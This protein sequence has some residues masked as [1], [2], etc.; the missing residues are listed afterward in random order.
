MQKFCTLLIQGFIK[1]LPKEFS[2]FIHIRARSRRSDATFGVK[3]W[4]P[5]L[6][7][8]SLLRNAYLNAAVITANGQEFFS[9]FQNRFLRSHPVLAVDRKYAKSSAVACHGKFIKSR[10]RTAHFLRNSFHSRWKNTSGFTLAQC[11]VV[12]WYLLGDSDALSML[13]TSRDARARRPGNS[14]ELETKS[15]NVSYVRMLRSMNPEWRGI[16]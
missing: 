6:K 14:I 12:D 5:Q 15:T 7:I 13:S 1:S 8:L 3:R 10:P 11:L 9:Q 4:Q 2:K 16:F